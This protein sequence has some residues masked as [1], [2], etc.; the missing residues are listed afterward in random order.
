[1]NTYRTTFPSSPTRVGSSIPKVC[2]LLA[3]GALAV[4]L[5]NTATAQIWQTPYAPGSAADLTLQFSNGASGN[6]TSPNIPFAIGLSFDDTTPGFGSGGGWGLSAIGSAAVGLGPFIVGQTNTRTNVGSGALSFQM[7]TSGVSQIVGLTMGSQWYASSTIPGSGSW[8]T[9]TNQF[10][11]SFDALLSDD[12]LSLSP[13]F[14]DSYTL[15]IES[16]SNILYQGTLSSI[17]PTLTPIVIGASVEFNYDPSLGPLD[18]SWSG[19]GAVDTTFLG[20][21]GN[22]VNTIFAVSNGVVEYNAVPEPGTYALLAA[23]LGA[24]TF[25]HRRRRR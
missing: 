24:V 7:V 23:S 2:T 15:T 14:F 6:A 18:I 12:I 21:L 20:F 1:M 19:D 25:F 9:P 16:N 22:G 4:F 17:L 5:P 8:V 11:Y 10:R 3:A 13:S